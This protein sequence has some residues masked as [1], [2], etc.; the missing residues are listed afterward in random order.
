MIQKV[1]INPGKVKQYTDVMLQ[2]S[3]TQS[4]P[5]LGIGMGGYIVGVRYKVSSTLMQPEETLYTE[6][7]I[8]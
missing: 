5:L 6:R 8:I 2:I 4:S 1:S 7:R 3:G